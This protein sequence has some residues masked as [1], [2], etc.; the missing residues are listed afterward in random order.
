METHE[1]NKQIK[2]VEKKAADNLF[3]KTNNKVIKSWEKKLL[4]PDLCFI[5]DNK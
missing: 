2:K 1:Q 3:R 4:I 5:T